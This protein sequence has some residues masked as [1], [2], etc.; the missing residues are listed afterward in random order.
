MKRTVSRLL[1]PAVLLTSAVGITLSSTP[2]NA[3]S[4]PGTRPSTALRSLAAAE[5]GEGLLVAVNERGHISRSIAGM[6]ST[7]S[8][9]SVTLTKPAGATVR[10]AFLGTAT[11][12]F[13]GH[14]LTS[15]VQ[16]DG[17]PVPI[18]G[19]IPN[20]ISSHNYLA[21]VTALVKARFD[22]A[23]AGP[24][25]VSY[26]EPVSSHLVDGSILQVIWDDPAVTT[27]Q[28]VTILYGA[29]K[30]EGDTYRVNL[31]S[32]IH[33]ADPASRLEMSL[34][35]SYS[36][37]LNGTQ[38]YS[39]IDVNSQRMTTSAGG[40]DDGRSSNGSLITVGGQGDSSTN[41]TNPLATPTSPRSDDELYDLLP[42]VEDGDTTIEVETR[43]PSADDNIFLATFTMNPP[44]T[45][46]TGEAFV[47]VA[48]GDS[49]Q[50]GEGAA[51]DLRPSATYLSS[52]YENGLN[53][54][55]AVGGQENTYTSSFS[56]VDP[57]NS[58]HRALR[59]Y[60]K[61]NRDKLAPGQPVVLVDR[62][63]SGAQVIEAA[64]PPIV[65]PFQGEVASNSQLQTAIDRLEA[66]GLTSSDVDLVTVGMG[67]NDA[68]FGDILTA[69][70]GPALIEGLLDQYPNAPG[71][72]HFIAE[73][74]ATCANVD[75]LFLHTGD[76]L[77]GLAALEED[78]QQ[79]IQQ[80]FDN[81][82]VMQLNY[83][84][85]LPFGDSPAWCGGLRAKD[86]DFAKQRIV[87]INDRIRQ[88][89]AA[90]GIEIVDVQDTFAPN[91]LCP[92]ESGDKLANGIEQGAF[93]TEVTRL[94]NVNGDGDAAARAKLDTLV[95]EYNDWKACWA[96]QISPFGPSCDTD[97]ALARLQAAGEDVMSYL[98]TQQ[99]TILAN[100]VSPPGTTDDTI[101]VGFD[102]SR[103]L[104]HPNQAGFESMACSVLA[105]YH[106]T[107][108]CAGGGDPSTPPAGGDGSPLGGIFGQL[109]RIIIEHFW[110][111]SSITMT[112]HSDP[113]SLGTVTADADGR[114]DT[115]ITV[116]DVPP[117][118][119]RLV[120]SGEA[121]D[122]A[123]LSQE[124]LIRVAGRPTGSYTTY[125]TGFAP[126]PETPTPNTPIEMVDVSVNG[127]PLGTFQADSFGG[128]LVSIPS[129]DLGRAGE[130]TITG[131][132]GTTGKV[133][134]EVVNPIPTRP[135]LWA[136]STGAD[137]I[138]VQGSRFSTDG[139]VHAEGSVTLGG[140]DNT[141][142]GGL[143]Y[144]RDLTLPGSQN[145]IS[146]AAVKTEPGQGSARPTTISDYRPGGEIA[147]T[148][149]DYTAIPASACVNGAWTPTSPDAVTGIVYVPCNVDLRVVGTYRAT[150]AAEG[151]ITSTPRGVTVGRGAAAPGAQA[152]VSGSEGSAITLVGADT[153]VLGQVATPGHVLVSGA[154][155]SLGCGAV[156]GTILVQGADVT[157]P[158][159]SWC[160][161]R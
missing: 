43:N 157:A 28:S 97:A 98:Q 135:A 72:I 10:K 58:C 88:A 42:F 128:V 50:S 75:N 154:R 15:P 1:A 105:Q 7:G 64:K 32:P 132:S 127:A 100:V 79:K 93:D 82:R 11:T 30:T 68:R 61:I 114:V 129:V 17:Q 51:M 152:L 141:L 26:Q 41:P 106:G 102:R 77:N 5:T 138:V 81:A 148:A 47:Y 126:R 70:V 31:A 16:L 37:Q 8:A 90:T 116:P 46:S 134:T 146:P 63:C 121:A 111:G 160:A 131:T 53:F 94:L 66:M 130:V 112:L 80:S 108:G 40:E 60:A 38:Q 117:G 48:M 99:A 137:A 73:N 150:I 71:E 21:E 155:T 56:G 12:G 13:T 156:G 158:M 14:R 22:T 89:A 110:P 2:A 142:T 122:G 83:P 23:P 151:T 143:E 29:L 20:G 109:L 145:T 3:E 140:T 107:A 104:F 78:A 69:C 149:P 96:E 85:I 101:D 57:A 144:G 19:E 120:L 76:A 39:V 123:Q 25:S 84:D 18:T 65:G 4:T 92:S 45:I 74:I 24:L 159:D 44:A 119:H 161:A 113:I 124:V 139:L 147:Q 55:D 115:T 34:G 62:T 95:G 59:N 153:T 33:P 6:A 49:Y 103:G 133:V 118:I 9:Q 91:A 136:T 67:G 36:S 27:E 35:I 86:V 87:D 54:P 125:L 52:G